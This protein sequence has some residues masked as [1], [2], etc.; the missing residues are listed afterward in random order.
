M[1]AFGI[2]LIVY[3]LTLCPSVYVEGTGELI[4]AAYLLGTAH[5]TGYP[6]FCLFG[7]LVSV[8]TPFASP[9][10]SVNLA[11]ALTGALAVASLA[12]LLRSRGANSWSCLGAA[13]GFAFSSS[14]W[15]Q[16]VIAEVYGLSL[17]LIGL[18]LC[19]GLRAIERGN[20]RHFLLTAFLCGLGLT[21]HLNQMLIV[22]GLLLLVLCYWYRGRSKWRHS[23]MI[24]GILLG[25]AGYSSALYLPLR[26]GRGPGFHWGS[27]HTFELVLEHL[28]AAS[29]TS[30][31]FL[32]PFEVAAS[33]AGR[34]ITQMV[35]EFHFLL[36][37]LALWGAFVACR[38]DGAAAFAVGS[39]VLLN[40]AAVLTYHRDPNG[41]GVFFL[42]S[43][44]GYAIFLGYGIEDLGRRFTA[45]NPSVAA[46]PR[47]LGLL[48]PLVVVVENGEKADRSD[49]WIPHRYGVEILEQLPSRAILFTEGDDASFA[50]DYLHRVEGIRPDIDLFNRMGRGTDLLA[51]GEA[52]LPP[53]QRAKIRRQKEGELMRRSE[54]SGRPV[55]F[56]FARRMPAEGFA[57]V[58]VGH[59][60]RA[61]RERPSGAPLQLLAPDVPFTMENAEREDVFTDP[62]VR[63]LQANYWYMLGER[64]AF[65]GHL[66]EAQA[67]YE[68]AARVGSDSRTIRYNTAII[69]MRR[70]QLDKAWS[71]LQ[72]ALRLDPMQSEFYRLG[73]TIKGRQGRHVEA[74]ELHKKAVKLRRIP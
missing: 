22:P 11:S 34:W 55:F 7:R 5:P 24:L 45:A 18:G 15:S 43:V 23:T 26:G 71:H 14:F 64:Q 60:Y 28:T 17:C 65:D 49:N 74:R 54:T 21:A 30:S 3:I 53:K 72:A 16:V 41:L 38:R 31:F 69:F 51:V 70:N 44:L 27:L 73:A 8:L 56:M 67:S 33:N 46:V 36:V 19:A 20:R 57:F 48:V 10:Y 35:S 42:V 12:V 63:K 37:P 1:A 59:L 62:W 32:P 40:L 4:G 9:A 25:A 58:P 29:Y 39:A 66:S 68:H 47:L 6:L 50:V 61:V 2:S 52:S 13:L